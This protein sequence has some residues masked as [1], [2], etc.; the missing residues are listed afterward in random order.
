LD[1]KIQGA[2]EFGVLARRLKVAGDKEL[3][4]ELYRGIARAVKPLTL[5]VRASIGQYVP[6]RY[7]A[8]LSTSLRVGTSKQS[9]RDP[10]VRLRATAKT[11]RG[12]PRNLTKLNQGVLRHPLYGNRRHWYNQPVRPGF[13]D[14]ELQQGAP[15]VRTELVEAIQTV[16]RKIEAGL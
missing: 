8:Q 4:K 16:A 5:S 9:G 11:P 15:K 1:I 14:T 13:W 12:K 2:E 10:G 6:A 7:A 3:R